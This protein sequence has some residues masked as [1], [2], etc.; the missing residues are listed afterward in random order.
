MTLRQQYSLINSEFND[1]LF[2]S[3]GDAENG[4][5]LTV[6]SALT[7]LGFDPWAEAAR[8]ADLPRETAARALG[9]ALAA[10]P[11]SDWQ[12]SDSRAIA[13]RLVGRLP[14]R[15][16]PIIPPVQSGSRRNW[17]DFVKVTPAIWMACI[18]VAILL[19]AMS[20]L[21]ADHD[22]EPQSLG[23]SSQQR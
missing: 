6:L 13:A 7:R 20:Y 8:L 23:V 18:L 9:T 5:E 19:V 14:R 17:R 11:E 4:A 21:R 12:I 3:L 10:L 2:E 1:F 15:G 16:S 22:G